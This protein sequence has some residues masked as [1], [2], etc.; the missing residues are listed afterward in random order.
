MLMAEAWTQRLG[1]ASL[2]KI[3]SKRPQEA[4]EAVAQGTFQPDRENDE[5]TFALQNPEHPGRIRGKGVVPWKYGFRE[6]IDSYQ[7]WQRRKDE[8]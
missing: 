3:Y 8:Q 7:S 5:L 2:A 6:Y 1:H 4:I